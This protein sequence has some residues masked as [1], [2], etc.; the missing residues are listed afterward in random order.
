MDINTN[1]NRL[2]Y[3]QAVCKYSNVT[4]AAAELNI[5]QPSVTTA[6]KDLEK[7]LNVI[8]FH[9]F[10]NKLVLTK[11]G[12]TVLTMADRLLNTIDNFF[13][14]VTDIS[15][16]A[17]AKVRLGAP[18]IM[19]TRLIPE[20]YAAV[21]RELPYISLEIIECGSTQA[22]KYLDENVL[23][24]A[25]LLEHNLSPDYRHYVFYET[26]FHFC[27]NKNHPLAKKTHI[28]CADLAD[29]PIAILSHGTSHQAIV[30]QMFQRANIKPI[31]V[32]QSLE[33]TTIR[34]LLENHDIGTF[35]YKDVFKDHP[36]IVTIPCDAPTDA[37]LAIAWSKE[38]YINR[39]SKDLISFF[40][41]H[42]WT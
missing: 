6:I 37:K 12:V 40:A 38:K 33:L 22:L 26:E 29:L 42:E 41:T 4:K 10:K 18:P 8:L 16:K 39:A 20:I 27:I 5:A 34:K 23:D 14:E 31:I 36:D 3:F 17:H 28:S 7:E 35:T 13:Q 21:M 25:V 19:G 11:E 30:N 15:E 9:R 24:L 1:L 32:L 2:R